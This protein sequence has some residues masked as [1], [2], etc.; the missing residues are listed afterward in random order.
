MDAAK[1]ESLLSKNPLLQRYRE[2]L[3]LLHTGAYCY[4]KTFGFGQ[5]ASYEDDSGKLIVDFDGKPRHAIDL[6]FALK[7]LE[8]TSAEHLVARHRENPE[9]TEAFL[10]SDPV[11]ALEVILEQMPEHR[12]TQLEITELV[13]AIWDEKITKTW[14]T[15]ARKLLESS[16]KISL[17][18]TKTGYYVL[19]DQPVEQLG[20]L[21][22]GVLMS[23]Q[24]AKKIAFAE[25]LLKEGS[26]ADKPED[27]QLVI[28]E[29]KR[30]TVS[31]SAA[32][33]ERLLAYWL[34]DDLC[35]FAPTVPHEPIEV[36]K[37]VLDDVNV[38]SKIADM[39]PVSRIGRL[40]ITLETLY[41]DKYNALTIQLICNGSQRTIG[42]VINLLLFKN[43]PEDLCQLFAQWAR[44]NSLKSNLL[45]WIF[46]NRD[47]AKYREII[48]DGVSVAHF[49]MALIL[50][51]QEATRRQA[52]RKIPLAELIANDKDLVE[53]VIRN[54]PAEIARDLVHMVLLNQGF[55]I[56]T[57]RSI[58]ARFIR[59][60]PDLQKLL[61]GGTASVNTVGSRSSASIG[62]IFVSQQSLDAIRREYESL[63]KEKIP[64][65]KRAVEIAREE[66]DLREN[67]EYK[68]ARQDQ[69][70]LMARK[71][72]IERDL[73]RAQVID[74]ADAGKDVVS[75]GNVVTLEDGRGKPQRFA[76]LGAWDSDPQ[77]SIIAYQTP[78]GLALLGKKVGDSIQ[79]E[80]R[81]EQKIIAI[82]RWVDSTPDHT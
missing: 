35:A 49:R 15:K 24:S 66:G 18:E 13:G 23:K 19:R 44:D 33:L 30:L 36:L 41:P 72:Q 58:V 48:K 73:A 67:S 29:L 80:G 17:P 27:L 11:G 32:A 46:K 68:M 1:M 47:N 77:R 71:S 16:G 79:L 65:N 31:P 57:K 26:G 74:F 38:V 37:G 55:D 69:D 59:I 52:N 39:L 3:A 53:E 82:E 25:R 81:E 63:I 20:E 50:I 75:I 2:K 54:E 21:I 8:P 64:S 12:A 10:K 61:D 78:I 22:D 4:H 6:A 43:G 51:D 9:E 5:I 14:W 40:L 42:G 62:M 70:M 76:I 34:G 56:L 45:E 28:E 60:F 7:H